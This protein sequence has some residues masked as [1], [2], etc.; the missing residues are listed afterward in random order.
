MLCLNIE[1]SCV[2]YKTVPCVR[3]ERQLRSACKR[4]MAETIMR[5]ESN[6]KNEGEGE[7]GTEREYVA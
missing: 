5:G 4:V 6:N 1:L 3:Y 2:R 7:S